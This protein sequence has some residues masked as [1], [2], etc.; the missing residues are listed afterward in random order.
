MFP[1]RLR[2]VAS[3]LR[4]NPNG[5]RGAEGNRDRSLWLRLRSFPAV[6]ATRVRAPAARAIRVATRTAIIVAVACAATVVHAS[7]A[8]AAPEFDGIV[9]EAQPVNVDTTTDSATVRFFPAP[10]GSFKGENGVLTKAVVLYT[11]SS[12]GALAHPYGAN[13]FMAPFETTVPLQGSTSDYPFHRFQVE[14]VVFTTA[15]GGIRSGKAVP[16]KVLVSSKVSGYRVAAQSTTRQG[17]T[18][19]V[20]VHLEPSLATQAFSVFI[21]VVMWA[22]ALSAVAVVVRLL[23]RTRR[24]EGSF[25]T[26]LAALLF[27]FPTVRNNLPGIPPVGVLFDYGAFFWAEALVALSLVALIIGWTTRELSGTVERPG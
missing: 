27:A 9:V 22:L 14:F 13:D 11:T 2:L 18:A 17:D 20:V 25:A 19:L 15:A 7:S 1:P 23:T 16:T 26:F 24:F 10:S 8:A 6:L 21:M 3:G 5:W 4:R 12:A